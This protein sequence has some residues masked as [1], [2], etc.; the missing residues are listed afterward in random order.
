MLFIDQ[1]MIVAFSATI[2]LS[3]LDKLDISCSKEYITF[4]NVLLLL[5]LLLL[6]Q[7]QAGCF[8]EKHFKP[9]TCEPSKPKRC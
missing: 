4:S 1:M 7:S 3:L 8:Y 5:L 2:Y 9:I 6:F